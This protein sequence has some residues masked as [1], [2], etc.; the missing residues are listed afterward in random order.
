MEETIAA[1]EAAGQGHVFSEFSELS[2]DSQQSFLKEAKEIDLDLVAS[3]F[4]IYKSGKTEEISTDFSP[5]PNILNLPS[6]TSGYQSVLRKDGLSLI[7]QNK[8][9]VLTF[10]GGQGTRLGVPYPK[11]MYDISLISHKTLFQLFAERLIGLRNIAGSHSAPIPWL[12]MVNGETYD[13]M[14]GFFAENSYFGLEKS[15]VFFFKQAMLPALDFEGKIIMSEKH[16]ICMAPNG[17]GGVYEGLL[18]SGGL[19]WLEN[20]GVKYLHICGIDNVLVKIC[21]PLFLSFAENNDADV[22]TKVVEKS[23]YKESVGVLGL[24]D[25]KQSIIDYSELSEEM[26]KLE[27]SNGKLL[28]FGGNILNHFFKIDFLRRVTSSLDILRSK[29]HIA[30]KKIP[31]YANGVKSTPTEANGVKF[32]LF[33][34]DIFSLATTSA[35]MEVTR[36]E[37]FAPVKNATGVDSPE[38]ARNLVSDLH[39]QW[40]KKAGGILPHSIPAGCVCE[41][42]PLVSVA[43]ENLEFL[44][45][46]KISLPFYLYY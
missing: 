44:A 35:A 4:A 12:I 15:Q 9:A 14:H 6:A 33:Y 29:Y 22:T 1:Y 42:S 32:E 43:G 11:G 20:K 38:S 5:F 40:V 25:G 45:D 27:D 13:Q 3:L 23:S 21:D 31:F 36:A 16:K 10:A 39:L 34:F 26:A 30:V 28:Y 17:N 2:A 18:Q 8:A 46:K 19:E 41:I 24:R 37:E 7:G